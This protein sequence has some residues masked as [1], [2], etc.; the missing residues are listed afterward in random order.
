MP[1]IGSLSISPRVRYWSL[2]ANYPVFESSLGEADSQE[3][4]YTLWGRLG[5]YAYMDM[6]KVIAAALDLA[7]KTL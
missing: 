2:L 5:S 7:Y 4:R 1:K 3:K 6:D